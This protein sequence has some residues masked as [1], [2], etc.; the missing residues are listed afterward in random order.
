M[1]YLC[2]LSA[3]PTGGTVLDPFMG[4]GTTGMACKKVGR[5]FIGIELDPHYLI[6]YYIKQYLPYFNIDKSISSFIVWDLEGNIIYSFKH[7]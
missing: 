7:Y 4:S 2:R 5:D 1:E 6:D 3:T